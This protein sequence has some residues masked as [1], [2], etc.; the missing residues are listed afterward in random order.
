M[1]SQG[2]QEE[3]QGG[4]GGPRGHSQAGG[5]IQAQG[6]MGHRMHNA[7]VDRSR[8]LDKG[9]ARKSHTLILERFVETFG[10]RL[11]NKFCQPSSR[12]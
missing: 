7:P 2:A 5:I 10:E 11:Q 12:L 6:P 9:P 8:F 1:V 3:R 4:P